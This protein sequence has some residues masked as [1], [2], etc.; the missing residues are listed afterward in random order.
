MFQV[1]DKIVHPMYG[2]G[3]V[4]SITQEKIDGVMKEYFVLKLLNNTMDV[5]IPVSSCA[6]IGMRS[7]VDAKVADEIFTA[8]PTMESDVVQNWNKRYRENMERLKSGDLYEVASVIKSLTDRDKLKGL[9]TGERKMLHS[10]RLILVSEIVLS[11]DV[12][13]EEIE[14]EL[15]KALA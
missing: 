6:D 5:M 15:D 3:V 13:Y 1:N 4:E 8:I 9:S 12:P 2:A 11:K 7:V 10:A 14:K